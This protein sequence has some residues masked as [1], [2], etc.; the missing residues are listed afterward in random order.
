M[1]SFMVASGLSRI[2]LILLG[3]L[4]AA[5]WDAINL[6]KE[7]ERDSQRTFWKAE[8]DNTY[9]QAADGSWTE[10]T[11]SGN[12]FQFVTAAVEKNYVE[13]LDASR[14]VSIRFYILL[15]R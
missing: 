6:A 12:C 1:A 2:V 13:L 14:K 15:C 5:G 8:K 11:L 7:A 9:T 4:A 3:R 10:V